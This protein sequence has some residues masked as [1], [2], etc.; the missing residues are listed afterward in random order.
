[1]SNALKM[2][3]TA[4]LPYK[5]TP[6]DKIEG[7][8]FTHEGQLASAKKNRTKLVFTLANGRV[9]SGMLSSFDPVSVTIYS[10]QDGQPVTIYKHA[11]ATFEKAKSDHEQ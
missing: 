10:D 6:S 9:I 8:F 5:P 11:I 1:M 3:D 7:R 4:T 2:P